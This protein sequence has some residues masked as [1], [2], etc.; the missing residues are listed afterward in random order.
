M[1]VAVAAAFVVVAG[2]AGTVAYLVTSDRGGSSPSTSSAVPASASPVSELTAGELYDTSPWI[3]DITFDNGNR[4][5]GELE[6]LETHDHPECPNAGL[7]TEVVAALV[8][9]THRVEAAYRGTVDGMVIGEQV[10]VF[11]NDAAAESFL[12]QFEEVYAAD[13]LPF[14][15]PSGVRVDFAWTVSWAD[16]VDRYVVLTAVFGRESHQQGAD[17]VAARNRETVQYLTTRGS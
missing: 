13:L 6:L 14:R 12:E 7:T 17:D 10:L 16:G 11:A 5:Q 4:I 1:V 9:C 3:Y 2:V 15:P 8:E